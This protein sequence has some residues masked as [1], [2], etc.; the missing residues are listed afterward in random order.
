MKKILT[1]LLA[2]V[3][4]LALAACGEKKADET[5]EPATEEVT[6]AV[7]EAATEAATEG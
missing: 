1:V 7:T 6:E 5:T 3:M 2:A 4:V